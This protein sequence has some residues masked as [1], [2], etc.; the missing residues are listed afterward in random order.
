MRKQAVN[1]SLKHNLIYRAQKRKWLTARGYVE[2]INNVTA[3]LTT[4]R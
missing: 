4:A 2:T 1:K 3:D